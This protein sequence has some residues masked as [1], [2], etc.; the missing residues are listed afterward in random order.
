[1]CQRG[2]SVQ[3]LPDLIIF[4]DTINIDV[5]Q[6][7]IIIFSKTLYFLL[8]ALKKNLDIF[9]ET[10][11]RIT[12]LMNVSNS[13]VRVYVLNTSPVNKVAYLPLIYM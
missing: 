10:P 1:M 4:T 12:S 5:V 6:I 8:N 2:M 3:E 11:C 13:E 9:N 7:F